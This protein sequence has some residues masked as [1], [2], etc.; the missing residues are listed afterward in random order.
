VIDNLET[1]ENTAHVLQE[2]RQFVEPSKFIVTSRSRPTVAASS[3]FLSLEE[4]GWED[5]AD[6]LRYQ[7]QT[8]GLTELAAADDQTVEAIF[9]VTGGNPLALKMVVSLAAVLPLPAV[10][11]DLGRGRAGPIEDL[12]R[13]IYW[14]A[15]RS[16]S[17]DAR[18]LL[19]AMP[20]VSE[21]GALPEQLLAISSLP[22]Q[23]LWL[24]VTELVSRSLLEVRGTVRER[25]Y[26]IHRL[27][28]SFL[29]TEIIDWE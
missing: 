9:Q 1:A 12:Y 15:W 11:A 2:I 28:E 22:E 16:L 3:Y 21:S 24:A 27:T 8:I 23:S 20:L 17:D 5:A 14:E 19:Q 25:R 10:L 7:A 26:G 6:L 13:N 29:R 18:S 4:L